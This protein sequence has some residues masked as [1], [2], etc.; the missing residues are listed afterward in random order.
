M[1]L[2]CDWNRDGNLLIWRLE[3]DLLIWRLD[4]GGFGFL[5]FRWLAFESSVL[6][7]HKTDLD[8][9]DLNLKGI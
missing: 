3:H 4:L 8:S 6:N 1:R 9:T 7:E 2:G 5:K